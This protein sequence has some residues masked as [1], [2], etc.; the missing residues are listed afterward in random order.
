M[1]IISGIY[2]G[3][4]LIGRVPSS[5]RPTTDFA[6]ESLFDTLCS[7]TNIEGKFFLDLFAGSGAIGLEALSRGAS[8][9][10]FID[11]SKESLNYLKKNIEYLGIPK[12]KYKIFQSEVIEF[13][14]I[15]CNLEKFE[16]IFADPPYNFEYFWKICEI[17]KT[18][19]VLNNDGIIIYETESKRNE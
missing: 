13:L 1:R 9:V 14:S 16:I 7:I 12:D 18:K 4:N 3:R 19:E 8:M 5:I 2:G 6:R 15:I 10:Y 11:K 17:I